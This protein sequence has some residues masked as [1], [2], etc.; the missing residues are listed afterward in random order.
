M[1]YRKQ[2][3]FLFQKEE[4]SGLEGA[5]RQVQSNSATSAPLLPLREIS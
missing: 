3:Q 4:G 2:Q 5:S 1:S